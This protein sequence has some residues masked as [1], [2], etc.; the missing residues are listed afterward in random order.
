MRSYYG[1]CLVKVEPPA[2][3]ISRTFTTQFY[4]LPVP[5]PSV[6]VPMKRHDFGLAS[7]LPS[8]R[9]LPPPE[10][11]CPL[12][13]S[14]WSPPFP[15]C[16][17]HLS[18]YRNFSSLREPRESGVESYPKEA[19]TP[20]DEAELHSALEDAQMDE[21]YD[22][23]SQCKG[24]CCTSV[25]A[26]SFIILL[27]HQKFHILNFWQITTVVTVSN[28]R[29][30]LWQTTCYVYGDNVRF[31]VC[32]FLRKIVPFWMDL[33]SC[34]L[35]FMQLRCWFCVNRSKIFCSM[36]SAKRSAERK[37]KQVVQSKIS[38]KIP[39]DNL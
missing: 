31:L 1:E 3:V 38:L 24:L 27:F 8:Q 16:P 37:W 2:D 29:N 23:M 19:A 4:D 32:S 6:S 15:I 13:T 35:K 39:R 10:L 33:C 7:G 25:S 28:K 26:S 9:I 14:K 36:C 20:V 12:A 22:R 18:L 30:R 11:D 5:H 21:R 17:E 34:K